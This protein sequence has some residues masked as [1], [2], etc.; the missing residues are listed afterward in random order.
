MP[1]LN[2][3]LSTIAPVASAA[4]RGAVGRSVVDDHD[5]EIRIGGLDLADHR[6]DRVLLVVRRDD[7][8]HARLRDELFAALLPE[9]GR[10][11]G[12]RGIQP[13]GPG[14]GA[15]K[16]YTAFTALYMQVTI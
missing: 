5:V 15:L 9:R 8:Q 1:R 14:A 6:G 7:H 3:S 10:R 12:H 4:L 16:A 2:G 13:A 11:F